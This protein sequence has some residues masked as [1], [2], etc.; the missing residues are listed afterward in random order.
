MNSLRMKTGKL[1]NN[2]FWDV[3][4]V[5]RTKMHARLI[6]V[7]SCFCFISCFFPK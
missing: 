3:N 6:L 7:M 2:L 5:N 1:K 4:V